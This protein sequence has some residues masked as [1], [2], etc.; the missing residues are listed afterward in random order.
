[1]KALPAKICLV[2]GDDGLRDEIC[3]AS[4]AMGC[5]VITDETPEAVLHHLKGTFGT[6]VIVDGDE[7]H[8]AET[9]CALKTATAKPTILV[10]AATANMRQVMHELEDLADD[11]IL[12]PLNTLALEIALYRACKLDRV[13]RIEVEAQ[14]AAAQRVETEQLLTARQVVD[15]MSLFISRLTDDLQG[16]ISYF[17]EMPNFV[18]I[19]DRNCMILTVNPVYLNLIG[20]KIGK[21]SWEIYGGEQGSR[22]DCPVAKT[23]E[24]GRVM[25]MHAVVKYRSGARVP[26]IVYT[27]PIY[28]N[29]GE[30]E[31]ILEV[32]AGTKEIEQL[33]SEIKST[34]QR[35]RQLFDAVPCYVAV[36]DRR[37]FITAL[38]RRF[39]KDFGARSGQNFHDLVIAG[40]KTAAASPIDRTLDD[41][42]PHQSEMV[43]T[44]RKGKQHIMLAWTSPITTAAGK[45]I[46]IL[47]IFMDVTELRTLQ[48]NLS[49]LGMMIGTVSHSL[50]G[51]LTGLDGAL[52]LIES[53]FYRDSPGKIE[54]GLDVAKLMVQRI[55]KL[56]VDILY[57]AKDRQLSLESTDVLQFAQEVAAQVDQRIRGADIAFACDTG[58]AH[59]AF[60]IDRT[61]VRSALVNILENAVEACL[62][63]TLKESHSISLRVDSGRNNVLFEIG[64]TGVGMDQEQT[65]QMFTPFY[66][67]KGERGTGLGLFITNKV[68]R[69]HGGTLTVNTN[70]GVGAEFRIQLPRHVPGVAR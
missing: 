58:N 50:K 33:S 8:A 68:I 9:V 45:L 28:D 49:T 17:N 1:M 32:F 27:A 16:G 14:T 42:K 10:A 44:S 60:E 63:D 64:D 59:G 13:A 7:S 36:L 52:Y 35:C 12:K 6:V 39:R 2:G 47:V 51:S 46:Q 23:I 31:L 4:L 21:H 26:V 30:V 56:V 34:Q 37:L 61:L 41:A 19:H 38:N 22:D 20:N 57:Y 65:K 11:F 66:S 62:A 15:K 67:T 53:G 54:E 29:D 5:T 40:G 69:K 18:A 24:S 25:S 70:P 55:R 3:A 48:D 43:L